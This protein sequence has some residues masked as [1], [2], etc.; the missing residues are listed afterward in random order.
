[1]YEPVT[2]RNDTQRFGTITIGWGSGPLALD[3]G[4]TYIVLDERREKAFRMASEL[5]VLGS[6]VLCISNAHPELSEGLWFGKR[7]RFISLCERP[8]GNGIAPGQLSLL[9]REISEFASERSNAVVLLDGI[10]YLASHNDFHR[11]QM[12]VEHLN[13]IAME[14]GSIMIIQTDAR[15][16]DRRSLARLGRFAETVG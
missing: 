7:P 6:E 11:L 10:E 4:R 9:G 14:M 3:Q 15:S 5:I 16:F 1:L 2:P 13:D 12:F 8:V